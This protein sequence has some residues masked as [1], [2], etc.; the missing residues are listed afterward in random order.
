[1][2]NFYRRFIL[3]FTSI[4]KPLTDLTKKD[5]AFQWSA[6]E[7]GMFDK[8]KEAFISALVLVYPDPHAP[9]QVETNALAFAIGA[10]LSQ[11]CANSEWQPCTYY[12]HALSGSK[13]N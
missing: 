5:H 4:V 8:L 9:L 7:Q 3:E 10:V 13:L 6:V 12:S 2:T 11:K 1:M